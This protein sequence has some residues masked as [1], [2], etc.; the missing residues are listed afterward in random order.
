MAKQKKTTTKAFFPPTVDAA[1]EYSSR[2]QSLLTGSGKSI[3][4]S[5]NVYQTQDSID[6]LSEAM[7]WGMQVL[8]YQGAPSIDFSNIRPANSKLGSG[9]TASGAVSFMRPF[10]AVVAEMRRE[11][12]KNGAGIAY[13]D[14]RHPE[15]QAFLDEPL[16]AAYKGVYL[17]PTGTEE[18][19]ELL[20]NE[21]LV[22]TL[23]TAYNDFR[24]FLVKRPLH[25]LLV[26]L[27]TEVEIPHRGSCVLGAINLSL[28]AGHFSSLS[29]VFL[30]SAE[31]MHRAMQVSEVASGNSPLACIDG[32][33][34]QF[35]LGVLGLASLL[36]AEGIS[37]SELNKAFER[38]FSKTG[39]DASIDL[40]KYT[41]AKNGAMT[42]AD[43]LVY[44]LFCAY[45][46]V[47]EN[48]RGKVRA[49]FC[50]QP[51]VSTAQRM[52]D[53]QSFDC[54]PEIQPVIGLKHK[55]GVRTMLKSA[56]KGD[57]LLTYHPQTPTIYDTSYDDYALT[58]AY[59][60]MMMESTGLAHRHSH[61]F[62]GE[63]FTTQ[64]FSDWYLDQRYSR[65]KSL[66]YRLP[67]QVN[68]EAMDKSELWQS[69]DEGE[70]FD[71]SLNEVSLQKYDA[72]T[73]IECAC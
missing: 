17:P 32:R 14:Y 54:S 5:C 57:R 50:I 33:N 61:C 39:Y 23:T 44:E 62:Y 35:G 28:F 37:Y 56:L 71:G 20:A 25:G 3:G 7:S 19:F 60:Q 41:S 59:W 16:K 40:L 72:S 4:A 53:S 58:S 13:L 10:D 69:V 27:C 1:F 70:L 55:D 8:A 64:R 66:Y 63:E 43:E 15:L 36:A 31:R 68:P 52:K 12:K 46:L 22:Q 47:T 18:A 9:G 21:S 65:I 30:A 51:T 11:Q 34:R 38:V 24:C 73:S 67:W 2:I 45:A 49:A 6:S 48:Y 29:E 42:K 26:N